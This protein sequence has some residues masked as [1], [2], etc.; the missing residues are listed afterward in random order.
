MV[1]ALLAGGCA[2]S[3]GGGGGVALKPVDINAMPRDRVRD[4]G[5][6]RWP[7]EELPPQWNASPRERRQRARDRGARRSHAGRDHHRRAG[8]RD[9]GSQLRALRADHLDQAARWSPTG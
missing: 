3:G 4:G 6:L 5:T 8:Q 2:D 7:I 9:R 1:V